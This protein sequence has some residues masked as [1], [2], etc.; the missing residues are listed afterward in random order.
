MAQ[1]MAHSIVD[2]DTLAKVQDVLDAWAVLDMHLGSMAPNGRAYS[3]SPIGSEML[4]AWEALVR[5]CDSLGVDP[6]G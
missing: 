2:A 6:R 5:V 4:D 3:V 1:A